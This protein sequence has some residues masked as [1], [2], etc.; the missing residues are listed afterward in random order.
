VRPPPQPARCGSWRVAP[1]LVAAWLA[2]GEASLARA[3]DA[4]AA[5]ARAAV[6]FSGPAMGSRYHVRVVMIPGDD[7]AN[8]RVRAAIAR[9]LALAERLFSRWRPDSEISR[10]SAHASSEPFRISPELLAALELARRASEL[11]EGA[12]D[13]TVAPLVDAWGFGPGPGEGRA[14]DAERLARL[15]ER[16]GFRMLSLD[17]ARSSV[18]KARPDVAC[19]LSGLAGGWAADRIASAL[20]ALG[21]RDVLV[22]VGGEV[23]ARG[24]RTDGGRWRVAVESPGKPREQALVIELAD[25]AVATSGDYRKAWTDA[26]GRRYG[27]V[28]DP[29]SG[30][31]VAHALASVTVVERDG[32]WA[33]ALATALLVLGPDDGR[34]LAA[35]ERLAA[36]FVRREPDGRFTEWAS[37]AFEALVAGP[38]P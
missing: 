10:L 32:A 16:V 24:R 29:R 22:D 23:A 36:R 13:A 27:H 30:R 37:A 35:R 4:P 33:D 14:P 9:E 5:V 8:E 2:A 11:S 6:S 20:G 17:R 12:F 38:K 28:L 26:D 34:A 21:H 1:A 7:A 3:K 15:R 19:D 31:P 25:A 18:T